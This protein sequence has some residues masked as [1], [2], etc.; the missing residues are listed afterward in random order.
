MCSKILQKRSNLGKKLQFFEKER[1]GGR[2]SAGQTGKIKTARGGP[3][4]S[5]YP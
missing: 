1:I 2:D 3:W 4:G 5:F